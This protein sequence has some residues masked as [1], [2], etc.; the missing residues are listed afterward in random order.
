MKSARWIVTFLIVLGFAVACGSDDT[1]E[2]EPNQ[3][4]WDL[5]GDAGMDADEL[6]DADPG[7]ADLDD[8]GPV[9]DAGPDE[10]ADVVA[11]A[12]PDEDADTPGPDAG[13]D[14]DVDPPAP[15][16]LTP[17]MLIG[18]PWYG[19]F[20]LT[21]DPAITGLYSGIEFVDE[22]SVVLHGEQEESGNWEILGTGDVHLYNL[23]GELDQFVLEVD[24]SDGEVE[25]LEVFIPADHVEPYTA[26]YERRGEADIDFNDL[27]A[28]WQSTQMVT[29]EEGVEYYVAIRIDADGI[30]ELGAA[31]E[32]GMFWGFVE[33]PG[34]TQTF[35]TGDTFW[36]ML[37]A[38]TSVGAPIAGEI[39][40]NDD[41]DLVLYWFAED[42][43]DVDDNGP[44]GGPG[45]PPGG[46]DDDPEPEIVV[47]EL[48]NVS[49]FGD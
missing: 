37:V 29:G 43:S 4:D 44:G 27:G 12:G 35:D 8:T 15:D 2:D 49:Q 22:D 28:R 30:M 11:D 16:E 23:E 19:V 46:G 41:G 31:G 34:T 25:A 1:G 20:R 21:D 42:Y 40:E 14:D 36:V 17:E 45:G 26:R 7:D 39:G 48:E 38:P 5:N 32:E 47:V 3:S 9:E 6:G 24:L 10:D 13:P 33:G 18:E